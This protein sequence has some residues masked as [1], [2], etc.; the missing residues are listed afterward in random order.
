MNSLNIYHSYGKV[1]DFYISNFEKVADIELPTN[2]VKLLESNN[3]LSTE[4]S[5]FKFHNT[6]TNHTDCRDIS[7]YGFGDKIPSSDRITRVLNLSEYGHNKVIIFGKSANGDFICF[8]YRHDPKT[9]EPKVVLMHHDVYGPDDK[10]LICP[11]ANS[12]DEFINALYKPRDD[13]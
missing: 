9:N 6:F 3:A 8:D 11:V 12:F 7:F 2:Y 5:V 1:E 4:E 10:M 13:E